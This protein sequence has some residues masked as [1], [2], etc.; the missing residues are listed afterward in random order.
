[1]TLERVIKILTDYKDGDIG[2]VT[3]DTTFN[4]LELDSLDV[5]D[6]V[7]NL[8]EEFNIELEVTEDI[9]TIGDLVKIIDAK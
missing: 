6:L 1:M 2:D 7:M 4:D 3:L 5:V 8:E 9:K